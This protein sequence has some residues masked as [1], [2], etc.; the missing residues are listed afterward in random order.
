LVIIIAV[1]AMFGLLIFPVLNLPWVE[2]SLARRVAALIVLVGILVL[3][4]EHAWPETGEETAAS[5]P[6]ASLIP[7]N[8]YPFREKATD[9]VVFVL[10]GNRIDVPTVIPLDAPIPLPL[11][12]VIGS[13]T[14]NSIEMSLRNGKPLVDVKM[15]GTPKGEYPIQITHNEFQVSDDQFG[16][17]FNDRA[18]EIVNERGAPVLQ[19]YYKTANEVVINGVFVTPFETVYVNDDGVRTIPILGPLGKIDRPADLKRMFKYPPVKY[20]GEFDP[21]W[22]PGNSNAFSE[23]KKPARRGK[24]RSRK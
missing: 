14:F 19:I 4:C 11:Q 10:G 15:W 3:L 13:P 18:F 6:V 21:K 12:S 2:L 16:R 24:S 20:L 7:Q 9:Q 17:N 1:L 22:E 8:Q 5:G 23:K